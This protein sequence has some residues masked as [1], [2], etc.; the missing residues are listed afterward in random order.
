MLVEYGKGCGGSG[1]LVFVWD[2]CE[3]ICGTVWREDGVDAG[4][5]YGKGRAKKEGGY[6]SRVG[7]QKGFMSLARVYQGERMTG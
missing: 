5:G 2:V 3:A 4:G 7:I 6:W 1:Y